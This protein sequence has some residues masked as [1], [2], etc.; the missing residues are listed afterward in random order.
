MNS[1]ETALPNMYDS[2]AS[3]YREYAAKRSAYLESVDQYILREAPHA[4]EILLDVGSG[5]GVRAMAIATRLKAKTTILSDSSQ[6]MLKKIKELKPTRIYEGQAE[7][8][9]TF[10]SP[11]GVILMLWNVLGHVERRAARIRALSAIAKNMDQNSLLFL[12]VN[13]RHN[14]ASYGWFNALF[15]CLFDWVLPNEKRG[16]TTFFWKLNGQSIPAK[17]HLFTVEELKSLIKASGLLIQ[18]IKFVDYATGKLSNSRFRG[19]TLL[20]LR[21][22]PKVEI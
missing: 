20:K 11:C 1:S 12:D 13:N 15:R 14:A 10:D 17:G 18:E 7:N 6:E 21:K 9:P 22:A 8:L 19:Q 4:P 2:M 5:D 3:H 16:D